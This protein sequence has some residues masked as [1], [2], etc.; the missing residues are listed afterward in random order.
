MLFLIFSDKTELI[1]DDGPY[2]NWHYTKQ[3]DKSNY[4]RVHG[5]VGRTIY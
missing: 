1:I 2:E 5:G 4:L 3:Y